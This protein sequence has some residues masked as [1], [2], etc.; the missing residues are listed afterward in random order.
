[1]ATVK[2]KFRSSS[3]GGKEGTVYYQII[4]DRAVRQVTTGYRV[5][6]LVELKKRIFYLPDRSMIY[7]IDILHESHCSDFTCHAG[8]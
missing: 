6:P 4:H 8:E 7:G 5:Y 1:M 3:V 2:V